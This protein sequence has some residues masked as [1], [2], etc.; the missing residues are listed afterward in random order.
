MCLT[1]P[2]PNNPTWSEFVS[3]LMDGSN[4]T[5][6]AAFADVSESTVGRWLRNSVVPQA[7]KVIAIC[8]VFDVSAVH[9]LIAAGYLT[10]D[11][12]ER[13]SQLPRLLDLAGFTDL[14]IA[15]ELV[16][17]LEDGSE[18]PELDEPGAPVIPIRSSTDVGGS[19]DDL[20]QVDEE[21]LRELPHAAGTDKSAEDI[22][23]ETT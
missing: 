17:R 16:R 5:V 7:E 1:F 3:A 8:R 13:S 10:T 23:P 21:E 4:N 9:G 15:Q 12:L 6:F 22:D 14:E 18:H 20:G 19:Q 2:V 11:D